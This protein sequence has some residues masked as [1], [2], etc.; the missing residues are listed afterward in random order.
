MKKTLQSKVFERFLTEEQL[1]ELFSKYDNSLKGTPRN[2]YT[3][4]QEDYNF[5]MENVGKGWEIFAQK[6]NLRGEEASCRK[7]GAIISRY[8]K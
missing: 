1:K 7:V 6:F 8:K 4:S 2:K 5:V 3:P